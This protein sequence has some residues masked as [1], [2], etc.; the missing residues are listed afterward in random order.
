MKYFTFLILCC[1]LSSCS[2]NQVDA[3]C[4]ED[5]IYLEEDFG[6]IFLPN[7]FTPNLDGSNDIYRI[8]INLKNEYE[9]ESF[10]I[11]DSNN[12]QIY[13]VDTPINTSYWGWDGMIDGEIQYGKFTSKL[14]FSNSSDSKVISG[15]LYSVRCLEELVEYPY[16]DNCQLP[17]HYEN[18]VVVKE[19]VKSLNCWD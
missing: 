10:Q 6:T 8:G 12:V 7:A 2:N 16:V 1:V 3:L 14:S 4:L 15:T 17:D 19:I 18:W 11:F 9:F 13:S 5:S